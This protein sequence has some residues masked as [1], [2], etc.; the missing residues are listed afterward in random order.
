[1]SARRHNLNDESSGVRV[2][3]IL[4]K[5]A[6][7]VEQNAIRSV[8]RLGLGLSDF[9]VLELLLHKGPQPVNVI[10]KKV[11]LTSG[12][13][14]TAVDRLESRRLVRRTGDPEDRRSRIVGLTPTGRRLI[15]QAFRR[16]A[17][18]MEHAL[19]AL[20]AADRASLVRLLKKAGLTAEE[21]LRQ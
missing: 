9:A 20:S 14:T 5:A 12:S 15:H 8:T 16:H 10:G 11:L 17:A 19:A 21:R 7:A 3:L 13:I 18:D 2:W 6:K 4:W 1:M